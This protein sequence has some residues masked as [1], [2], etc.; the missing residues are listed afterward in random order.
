MSHPF[1]MTQEVIHCVAGKPLFR[2]LC[3]TVQRGAYNCRA[4]RGELHG[5]TKKLLH[6]AEEARIEQRWDDLVAHAQAAL[7][8]ESRCYPRCTQHPEWC[9]QRDRLF[10]W[11]W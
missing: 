9:D 5:R 10:S 1:G 6:E 2:D 3:P 7:G 11:P 8:V 4:R